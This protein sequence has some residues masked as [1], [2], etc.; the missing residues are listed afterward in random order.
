MLPE[1]DS[2][3]EPIHLL[4]VM[5]DD[6]LLDRITSYDGPDMFLSILAGWARLHQNGA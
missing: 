4:A 6:E 5:E 1:D 2:D 3:T